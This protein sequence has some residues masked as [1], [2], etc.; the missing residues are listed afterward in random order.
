MKMYFRT[1]LMR[2]F[3]EQRNKLYAQFVVVV[4]HG[5]VCFVFCFFFKF[6]IFYIWIWTRRTRW[7]CIFDFG[8]MTR[9]VTDTWRLL[10]E[11]YEE[12]RK[13]RKHNKRTE[14]QDVNRIPFTI[15]TILSLPCNRIIDRL[16]RA[17]DTHSYHVLNNYYLF[18]VL[19]CIVTI[20]F[21]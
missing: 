3:G 18:I 20:I 8:R 2:P 15:R 5:S 4:V 11:K 17:D 6:L 7:L 19:C 1:Y 14:I 10:N 21:T 16:W 13:Q 12:K 9:S